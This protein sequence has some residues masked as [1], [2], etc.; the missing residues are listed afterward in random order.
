MKEM[1]LFRRSLI[2]EILTWAMQHKERLYLGLQ[3]LS[4]PSLQLLSEHVVDNNIIDE[5]LKNSI[6]VGVKLIV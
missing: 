4:Q 3:K 2:K 5:E 1:E 6:R